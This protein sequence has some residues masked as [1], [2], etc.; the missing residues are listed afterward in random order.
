MSF[1]RR[2]GPSPPSPHSTLCDNSHIEVKA[3]VGSQRVTQGPWGMA[4]TPVKLIVLN[5]ILLIVQIKI[6]LHELI[7]GYSRE[8]HFRKH[9]HEICRNACWWASF[10]IF[11]EIL[12][13]RIAG[14]FYNRPM[15][16]I[17]CKHHKATVFTVL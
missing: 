5:S 13:G 11:L 3:A 15:S 7:Q 14:L 10:K 12:L 8:Y 17:K 4:L 2:K 1:A 16:N 9:P 6:T